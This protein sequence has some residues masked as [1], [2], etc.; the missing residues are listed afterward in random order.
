MDG[1]FVRFT[2]KVLSEQLQAIILRLVCEA[3][4][5]LRSHAKN[6]GLQSRSEVGIRGLSS[7]SA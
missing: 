5:E 6:I 7:S 3:A 2:V 1:S 4:G